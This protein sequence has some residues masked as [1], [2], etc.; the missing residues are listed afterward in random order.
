MMQI[1]SDIFP[2]HLCNMVGL[3]YAHRCAELGGKLRLRRWFDV[4]NEAHFV[5]RLINPGTPG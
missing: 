2:E 5:F 4:F 1:R 3:Q